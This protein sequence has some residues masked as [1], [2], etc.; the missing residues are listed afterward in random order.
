MFQNIVIYIYHISLN[1]LH[2]LFIRTNGWW[3]NKVSDPLKV[4][5]LKPNA[6]EHDLWENRTSPDTELEHARRQY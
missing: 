3:A 2:A 4:I 6:S 5:P 1:V